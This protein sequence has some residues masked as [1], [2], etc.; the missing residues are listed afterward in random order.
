M[1][2]VLAFWAAY[3]MRRPFGASIGDLLTAPHKDGGL[4]FGTNGTSAV[5]LVVILAVVG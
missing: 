5:F 2:A 1:D 4:A 3:V